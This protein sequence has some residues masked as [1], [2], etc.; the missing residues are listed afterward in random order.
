[1][2]KVALV[3]IKRLLAFSF[4]LAFVVF[5]VAVAVGV[6]AVLFAV[7]FAFARF[8]ELVWLLLVPVPHVLEGALYFGVDRFVIFC[9]FVPAY[10]RGLSLADEMPELV[11]ILAR[12]PVRKYC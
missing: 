7:A 9:G 10:C 3:E 6:G 8:V 11:H 2:W 12:M 5:D 1:M 4:A